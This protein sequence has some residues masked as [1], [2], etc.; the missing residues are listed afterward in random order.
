[1]AAVKM[2]GRRFGGWKVLS[3]AGRNDAGNA[4]WLCQCIC[5]AERVFTGI[6][7]RHSPSKSCGCLP[8]PSRLVGMKGLR[9]GR[10]KVIESAGSNERG[11]GMWLCRCDCGTEAAVNGANLRNGSSESCGC[12][13]ESH[14]ETVGAKPTTEYRAWVSML[15]RCYNPN[16]KYW[17]HYGGRGIAVCERWRNNYENF[18]ADM[19]RRP[20][21]G[22]SI[23]RYP[24]NDGNYEPGNCRWATAKQQAANKRRRKK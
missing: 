7:L 8:R 17:K 10:W 16:T 19:G 20:G 13:K 24:D 18:L 14:L 15:T 9:F 5:G 1:M 12:S 21:R 4:L 22:Y 11:L 23:D 3:E 6:K 2:K